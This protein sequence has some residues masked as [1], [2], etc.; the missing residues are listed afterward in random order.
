MIL[1]LVVGGGFGW[2]AHRARV[3]RNA[4]SAIRQYGGWVLFDYETGPRSPTYQRVPW[5]PEWL[6]QIVGD[7]FFQEIVVA[8]IVTDRRLA[9]QINP[10][11]ADAVLAR[12]DGM[13]TIKV[14]CLDFDN[15]QGKAT[16]AGFA[17]LRGL[18]NLEDLRV[19]G[20][21]ATSDAELIQ[22]KGLRRLKRLN[23]QDAKLTDAGLGHLKGLTS[24]EDLMINGNLITD[25][26]LAQLRGITSLKGLFIGSNQN[27]VTDDG[28]VFLE[29]LINLEIL[30]IGYS[31]VTDRGLV[32][33][34]KLPK[35]KEI[36]IYGTQITDEG[37][38]SLEG[39]T[40][41]EMLDISF[42]QITDRGLGHLKKL[43]KLKKICIG[44]TQITDEG[45]K[46]LQEA[47]PSL[48]VTR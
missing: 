45:V 26:G 27:E 40:N 22:L 6:R 24:L 4:L 32:H 13:S 16:E 31:R 42:S 5:A 8:L 15:T 38:A 44:G 25:A 36:W 14:L 47:M 30:D 11:P 7:E 39:M 41:L 46:T 9:G 19:Y 21:S 12:I 20:P 18:N 34:K 33:L 37:L 28:L 23:I 48:N 2:L 43:P 3:Q 1:V 29:G 35:L 17:H 10:P